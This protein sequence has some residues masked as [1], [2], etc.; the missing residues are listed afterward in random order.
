MFLWT[1][2]DVFCAEL[3]HVR[4][5]VAMSSMA[6]DTDEQMEKTMLS[7]RESK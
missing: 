3:K 5:R 2:T 1:R 7:V 6:S 4:L